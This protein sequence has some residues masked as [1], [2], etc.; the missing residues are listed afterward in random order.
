M[1]I[2]KIGVVISFVMILMLMISIISAFSLTGMV[3]SVDSGG[4]IVD[5][6]SRESVSSE[7]N[8]TEDMEEV[9]TEIEKDNSL[10][11]EIDEVKVEVKL[12]EDGTVEIDD[13]VKVETTSKIKVEEGS[14]S[15][16]DDDGDFV[17]VKILATEAVNSFVASGEVNSESEVELEVE[18]GVPY[19]NIE[20][21]KKVKILWII[22]ST[23]TVNVRVNAQTG[24]E[25]SDEREGF[26]SRLFGGL[27]D[28]EIEE[29]NIFTGT[30]ETIIVD[31]FENKYSETL[32]YL[33]SNGKKYKLISDEEL[34]VYKSGTEITVIGQINDNVISFSKENFEVRSIPGRTEGDSFGPQ[35]TLVVVV[36]I[37]GLE[38][39][40]VA[41]ANYVN[42]LYFSDGNNTVKDYYEHVSYNQI[43]FVGNVVGPYMLNST[44]CTMSSILSSSIESVFYENIDLSEY[45]RIVIIHP[46]TDC[47]AEYNGVASKGKVQIELPNEEF[48][49]SSYSLIRYS[50]EG[51]Y[52]FGTHLHELGHN[53]GL[54]HSSK[55]ECWNEI[56]HLPFSN[57]CKSWEYG[58]IYDVM[59]F[60]PSLNHFNAPYKQE[61]GWFSEE[62]I[63]TVT[64]GSFFITP[65]EQFS[66]EIQV[67]NLPLIFEDYEYTLEFRQPLNYDSNIIYNPPYDGI[68]IHVS[69]KLLPFSY[70]QKTNL[71]ESYDGTSSSTYLK[72]GES[73]IDTIN[74]YN[75]TVEDVSEEG[76]HVNIE[77]IPIV[78]PNFDEP[79]LYFNFNNGIYD[80]M[81]NLFPFG[82]FPVNN[83]PNILSYYSLIFPLEPTFSFEEGA[84]YFSEFTENSMS[85]EN[86]FPHG[87]IQ[88][89]K[90]F[91]Y[92]FFVKLNNCGGEEF[93]LFQT[94]YNWLYLNFYEEIIHFYL[95]VEDENNQIEDHAMTLNFENMCDNN[96]HNILTTF[97]D[98]E[99][100]LYM[101]GNL[102]GQEMTHSFE[103]FYINDLFR[104]SLFF[105][106]ESFNGLIDEIKIYAK[107]LSEEEVLELYH[108]SYPG[109]ISGDLNNDGAPDVLDIVALV[110]YLLNYE[111]NYLCIGNPSVN[112]N[113][114]EGGSF[115][116]NCNGNE[117]IICSEV[118]CHEEQYYDDIEIVCDCGLVLDCEDLNEIQCGEMSNFGCD[119]IL[120]G[121]SSEQ[122]CSADYNGDGSVDV[123]DIIALVDFILIDEEPET[124]SRALENAGYNISPEVLINSNAL[125]NSLENQLM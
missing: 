88:R 121:F 15:V 12:K 9:E 7:P 117:P 45:E 37:E 42:T 125:R 33:N 83:F 103:S 43:T 76:V 39:H 54:P 49:E 122:L 77:L 52:L 6:V 67:I 28:G 104:T 69:K 8:L 85:L 61:L 17:K 60:S 2:K 111:E 112:C 53:L 86:Y 26:F 4:W 66:E 56:G 29:E 90:E 63:I 3:V 74:G 106:S 95:L 16:E 50:I 57:S 80:S 113:D 23:K 91:T 11:V 35:N 59:G 24:E 10:E 64:N 120:E 84:L 110:E 72:I 102:L 30:L 98:D 41:D 21:K 79:L 93:N 116:T 123:L 5:V 55:L 124:I 68:I 81:N 25:I 82:P 32:L 13:G 44:I 70:H 47:M 71:V 46:T 14:L 97:G 75:I 22:P 89:E 20:T 40:P 18:D 92:S 19:Y 99:F 36:D 100:K 38:E 78:E 31:D 115:F 101:D 105:T 65:L 96:W 51:D 94:D 109:C 62:N 48:I 34:P 108:S 118:N 87:Y 107:A 1:K 27:F 73:F 119:W 114:Y 58:D